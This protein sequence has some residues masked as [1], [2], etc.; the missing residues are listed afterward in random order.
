MI[1]KICNEEKEKTPVIRN[2][3]TRFVDQDGRMWNG[4]MCASCYKS[5]NRERMRIKRLSTKVN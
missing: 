1:C 5:Y 4:R 3:V 2:N